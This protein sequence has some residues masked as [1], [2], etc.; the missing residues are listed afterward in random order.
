[1]RDGKKYKNAVIT[2]QM[3]PISPIKGIPTLS[4]P[5]AKQIAIIVVIKTKKLPQPKCETPLNHSPQ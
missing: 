2:S 3:P 1:M 5:T 4:P